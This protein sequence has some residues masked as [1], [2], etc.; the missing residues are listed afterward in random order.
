MS[1]RPSLIFRQLNIRRTPGIE[2]PF[3]VEDLTDGINITYGPNASGK[4]TT[5]QVLQML[6][7]NDLPDWSRASIAGRIDFNGSEWIVDIDAGDISTRQDG[8][9]GGQLPVDGVDHRDRYVLSLHDL[10]QADNSD[11]A[12]VILRESSGG[13]DVDAASNQLEYGRPS[14][15]P[16][17]RTRNLKSAKQKVT[18]AI[19]VQRGLVQ[20]QQDLS[21]LREQSEEAQSAVARVGLLERAISA[22]QRKQELEVARETLAGMPENISLLAGDELDRLG[23]LDERRSEYEQRRRQLESEI[24]NAETAIDETRLNHAPLPEG[25]LPALR[26][27]AR[28]LQESAVRLDQSESE[29]A[30]QTL[31]RDQA[32][33]QLGRY[34]EES[35]LRAFETDGLHQLVTIARSFEQARVEYEAAEELRAWLGAQ[36]TFEDIDRLRQGIRQLN[37]WLRSSGVQSETATGGVSWLPAVV[38]GGLIALVSVVGAIVGHPLL[39]GFVILAFVP[40]LLTFLFRPKAAPTTN[41]AALYQDEY[42]RLGL[43]EPRDWSVEQVDVLTEVLG[44]HLHQQQLAFAR[45]ERWSGLEE[46]W[47]KAA[48]QYRERDA[49]W[50]RALQEYGLDPVDSAELYS[51]AQNLDRWQDADARVSVAI[52][53]VDREREAHRGLL[54]GLNQDL[55]LAG[56]TQ[57][58]DHASILGHINDLDER[59]Q[60][61]RSARMTCQ[62]ARNALEGTTKLDLEQIERERATLF[63]SLGLDADDE[64]TLV[65]WVEQR[66][67]YLGARRRVE[68]AELTLRHATSELG[69]D[70]QLLEH[71]RAD[72]EAELETS[73]LRADKAKELHRR[74]IEIETHIDAAK[75]ARNLEQAIVEEEHAQ[76]VLR[77]DREEGYRLAVG[78]KLSDYVRQQT[79]DRDRPQVFHRARELFVLMTQGRYELQF[80]DDPTPAFRAIDTTTNANH[81][82]D[83]LSSATRVQLLMAVRMAFVEEMEHGPRLPLILDETLG[84]ADEYRAEAI[85][86][87]VCEISRSGR[88]VFYFTAQLDEV[89][90]W[91]RLLAEHADLPHSV[92]SL[93]EARQLPES[94]G[95]ILEDLPPAR[96]TVPSPNGTAHLEYG[97][98]LNVPPI[99]TRQ[100]V[101]G[102]HLW[103]LILEPNELH[104]LLVYGIS[105]WGQLRTLVEYGGGDFV[106]VETFE[107]ARARA[108]AIDAGIGAHRIGQGRLVDR[109]AV[110][111]SEAFSDTFEERVV[112]QAQRAGGDAEALLRRLENRA[113]PRLRPGNIQRFRDYLTEEGYLDLEDPLDEGDIRA[114][115]LGETAESI[116]CGRLT[117]DDVEQLLHYLPPLEN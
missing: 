83:E 22:R 73:R 47:R 15:Y 85:I 50:R 30:D 60:R 37:G 108:D 101:E 35:Q 99:D 105:T 96:P 63:D 76:D 107:V 2:T 20:E 42:R 40:F 56:Y 8:N 98:I 72:L 14:G 95:S 43:Q 46:R 70:Q 97:D 106:D 32:A 38:A 36:A 13:Y 24:L 115:V 65:D 87:A 78:A 1:G 25:F 39:L 77:R 41:R 3:S 18:Q 62:S 26:E 52:A 59:I 91:R 74:I 51:I 23:S 53:E 93:V 67:E 19:Q 111:N 58:T 54:E 71:S 68:E 113:V 88:Q 12:D 33:R 21:R 34:A 79:R 9:E 44:G 48:A 89:G 100:D 10:L 81:S 86:R 103:Y 16:T 17:S 4:S 116:A 114:R 7:W 94:E 11:F 69:D 75:E 92:I 90:K 49:D 57:S 109:A 82:L 104:R 64:R 31:H 45:S 80:S 66:E 28:Q 112:G 5:A 84:N 27:Q 117:N 55:A 61:L 102:V 6:L 110:L 29:L